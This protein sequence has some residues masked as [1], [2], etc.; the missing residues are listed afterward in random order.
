M[1]DAQVREVCEQYAQAQQLHEAGV[2]L[3]STDEKTGLQALERLHP[4][5]PVKQGLVERQE[6]EYK[7]HGTRCVIA[8]LE[9]ATGQLISP[10]IGPTRTSQDFT[11]PLASSIA[12]SMLHLLPAARTTSSSDVPEDTNTR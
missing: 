4:S 7:R 9:V 10:S 1:H 8:Y 2:H 12:S 6:S 5:L 3:V 11:S